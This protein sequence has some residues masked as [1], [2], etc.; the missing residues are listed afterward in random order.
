MSTQ[1]EFP[2]PEEASSKLEQVNLE[3][4][5]RAQSATVHIESSAMEINGPFSAE[6]NGSGI[7]IGYGR[8]ITTNHTPDKYGADPLI[9][10]YDL[11]TKI[12][13]AGQIIYAS[14]NLDIAV[15]QTNLTDIE[16]VEINTE[17][18]L[19]HQTL[20]VTAFP[21]LFS[22][23]SLRALNVGDA[24]DL[25]PTQK[26]IETA[27]ILRDSVDT[28]SM[29]STIRNGFSGGGVFNTEGKLVGMIFGRSR[30]EPKAVALKGSAI[31]S[32]LQALPNSTK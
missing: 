14:E 31:H 25:Y 28:T 20:L 3:I 9:N 17:K 15:L 27:F 6:S 19:P 13:S 12:F 5:R 18:L 16:K 8:I 21:D 11:T 1:K 4:I 24:S 2:S 29:Y 10:V 23:C 22:P 32:I 7:H 30:T 26:S